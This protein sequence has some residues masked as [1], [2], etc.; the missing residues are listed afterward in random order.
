MKRIV[1]I[2]ITKADQAAYLPYFAG[3]AAVEA[4]LC[5]V[6]VP[7]AIVRP[8]V[9]FGRGDVLINNIAWL[10]RR[11]PL[12][13]I[14]GS[15]DYR[16]RPVHVDDVARICIEV[17]HSLENLTVDAVGP[18]IMSFKEMV[19]HI[20]EAVRSRSLFVHA[21]RWTPVA[22]RSVLGTRPARRVDDG[23]AVDRTHGGTRC[24]GWTGDGHYFFSQL[25][26]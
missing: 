18:E 1:H 2:S 19:R 16:V 4:A 5:E 15:G 22:H 3:K 8:T 12:F 23:G 9:V 10:L 17:G 21:P 25:G 11:I 26:V 24:H 20:R 14:A 7:F 6:G 13:V